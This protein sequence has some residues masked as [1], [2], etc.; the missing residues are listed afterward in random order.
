MSYEPASARTEPAWVRSPAPKRSEEFV[1]ALATP[2]SHESAAPRPVTAHASGPVPYRA[3]LVGGRSISETDD[4]GLAELVATR[5]A[6]LTGH[7]VDLE[8]VDADPFADATAEAVLTDRDLARIDA[9]LVVLDPE[10]GTHPTREDVR[11]LL[12]GLTQRLT[13]GSAVVAV[14]PSART[15]Q[16]SARELD[17]FTTVVQAAA[18]VLI[19]VV[20]LDELRGSTAVGRAEQW[21]GAIAEVA[22]RSAIEPM[23]RFLPSDPF[24]ELDRADA[25]AAVGKRYTA[26]TETFQ[27]L[28]EAARS[29]YGT[30][31][32]AMSIIDDETTRYF[33]RSGNV[34]ESLPRGKTVCNRVMRIFGGLILGDARLDHRFSGLPEVKT[35][36]V[37]FYAGYRIT[38]PDGAPFGALCVFDSE[39]RDVRD[40][41][42]SALR[43]LALDAQ[44]RLW[45]LLGTAPAV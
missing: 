32:A 19:P 13:P 22:A 4:Q 26:W 23:V 31:A 29:T 43:D 20:R 41:D 38:G 27:D 3:L 25:V 34:A 1:T 17:R 18:E 36:D 10:R 6:Q 35:G 24:D 9:L 15:A 7:G 39:P 11:G 2:R 30:P 45:D 37:R 12:D 40:E 21:A 42:L 33:T 14:L 28:V 16:L 8:L 5:L 44:R